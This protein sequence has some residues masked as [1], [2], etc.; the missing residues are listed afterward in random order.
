MTKN[1]EIEIYGHR[2]TIMGDAEEDYIKRLAAY[3]DEQMRGVAQGMKTATFAK[4][5]LLA[6]GLAN[7]DERF[8]MSRLNRRHSPGGHFQR[9]LLARNGF[10]LALCI[11]GYFLV[12]FSCE[13]VILCLH[14]FDS[15]VGSS[16][17]ALC[18]TDDTDV[19][20]G[21]PRLAVV[22]QPVGN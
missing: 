3:V 7:I 22:K 20:G 15:L 2:Y 1:I 12:D 17:H 21:R 8:L 11:G 6:R 9:C 13:V 4:L 16:T 18:C 19:N 10:R 14:E 5:A